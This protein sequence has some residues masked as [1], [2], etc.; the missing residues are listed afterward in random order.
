MAEKYAQLAII[1][2]S[3]NGKKWLLEPGK[4]YGIGRNAGNTIV[5]HDGTVSKQHALVEHVDGIWFV[6]DLGSKHGTWV[7][8][9]RIDERR[10]LFHKDVLRMGKTY[11]VFG[12]VDPAKLK[13]KADKKT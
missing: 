4:H 13:Q 10:A 7:N 9:E 6:Q 1:R 2:G 12:E 11:L 8:D 5:L 3:D